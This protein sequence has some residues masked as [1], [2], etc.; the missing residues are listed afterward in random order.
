MA[1]GPEMVDLVPPDI[2]HHICDLLGIG[3]IAV[4]QEEPGAG[5]M[6]VD[7]DGIYPARVEGG[8]PAH[9]PVDFVPFRKQQ[10]GKVRPVLAG[11]AGD[12]GFLGHD[13]SLRTYYKIRDN[14]KVWEDQEPANPAEERL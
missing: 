3:E 12:E 2:I 13:V 8:G 11:D 7:I 10:F 6:R 5:F 14:F 9:H 1:L 4:V